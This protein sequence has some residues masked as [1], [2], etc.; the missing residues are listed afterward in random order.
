MSPLLAGDRPIFLL[1]RSYQGGTGF[2]AL[3]TAVMAAADRRLELGAVVTLPHHTPTEAQSIL[4]EAAGYEL[5]IADP[6]FHEHESFGEALSRARRQRAPYL[7]G[8]LP[9]RPTDDVIDRILRVQRAAGATALLTPTGAVSAVEPERALADA[10]RWVRA[11]RAKDPVEPLLV[12]L[13]LS[14]AWLADPALREIL[15]NE[16]VDSAETNWYLRVRWG[17][18]R[19]RHAQLGDA[20]L[21]R[22]YAVVADVLASEQKVLLLPQT[23]LTGWLMTGLGA[24]GFSVGTG[25]PEQAYAEP[26]VIRIKGPRR[27][28]VPR[29]FEPS[30]L[31]TVAGTTQ[32]N[33]SRSASYT[34]CPCR[35]CD[36]M[37]SSSGAVDPRR[38]QRDLAARHLVVS[39]AALQARLASS[40]R[41]RAARRVVTAARGVE[42]AAV[43]RLTGEDRPVHL[44]LWGDLLA[45]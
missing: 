8:A 32:A 22:G 41:R 28:P 6:A 44:D 19:P 7:V 42:Q 29:Y 5:R 15:L 33:I 21:L 3:A 40:D 43:P 39:L 36:A 4:D 12:G 11:T 26:V 18:L 38:W 25:G 2:R 34:Q 35:Y 30:L 17:H 16:I 10:M 20:G 37:R 9:R 45:P 27:P 13:T 23:G 14:R 24:A 1:H 31:H